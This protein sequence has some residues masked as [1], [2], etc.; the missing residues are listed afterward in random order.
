[1][2]IK[3]VSFYMKS[4]VV[5]LQ[6]MLEAIARIATYLG[7]TGRKGFDAD[8]MLQDAVIRQLRS[9]PAESPSSSLVG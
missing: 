4:D 5:Y 8:Q 1:M 6:H 7:D 2:W 9:F 3:I